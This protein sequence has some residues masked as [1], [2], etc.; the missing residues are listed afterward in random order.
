M[1]VE[2]ERR[3]TPPPV[4][5]TNDGDAASADLLAAFSVLLAQASTNA[6][7][8][9]GRAAAESSDAERPLGDATTATPQDDAAVPV[10]AD[11]GSPVN[12]TP[13]PTAPETPIAT[14]DNAGLTAPLT[15]T[16]IAGKPA[17]TAAPQPS[18]LT[19]EVPNPL[20][21]APG[22]VLEAPGSTSI[23]P[24]PTAPPV[25]GVDTVATVPTAPATPVAS[26]T[27]A[28][29][30][31]PVSVPSTPAA[32]TT[33]APDVP[34]AGTGA[35]P[36]PTAPVPGVEHRG[37][38]PDAG[39]DLIQP[40]VATAPPVA[41]AP[42]QAPGP[43][44]PAT[45]TGPPAPAIPT[46]TSQLV[47]VLAPLRARSDGTTKLS[48]SLRPEE[49][50]RVNVDLRIERGTVHV[51]LRAEQ[52]TTVELL[53]DTIDD[54]RG[55]LH[56]RGISTGEFSVGEHAQPRDEQSRANPEVPGS[57]VDENSSDAITDTSPTD[58]DALVDVRM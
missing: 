24:P 31:A 54:L 58:T 46:A 43:T 16:V 29:S 53:R 19:A 13:T 12:A 1:K 9:A 8:S 21:P 6:T 32:P 34:A 28:T 22:P 4:G 50:G 35:A 40:T 36:V 2:S 49:L 26:T 30:T 33:N 15:G 38:R 51:T 52:P 7:P 45:P 57:D 55:Q 47:A 3:I 41:P 42:V 11:G 17:P 14:T 10:I 37:T 25:G 39:P 20:A 18:I 27:T 5:K 48:L 56:D 23:A 44:A